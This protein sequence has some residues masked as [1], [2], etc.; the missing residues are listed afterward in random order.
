MSEGTG[1]EEHTN[2]SAAA[3][4]EGGNMA[5]DKAEG[6]AGAAKLAGDEG[7][8]PLA[9]ENAAEAPPPAAEGAPAV[10]EERTAPQAGA[11]TAEVPVPPAKRSREEGGEGA[12]TAPVGGGSSGAAG[13]G[14]GGASEAQAPAEKAAGGAAAGEEKTGAQDGMGG[15]GKKKKA[16]RRRVQW[17]E[18]NLAYWEEHK[19]PR[20]R[21]DEPKTPFH[22]LGPD[23]EEEHLPGSSAAA[24]PSAGESGGAAACVGG[25]S[26]VSEWTSSEDEGDHSEFE[27]WM[28]EQ[29]HTYKDSATLAAAV[30]A[31][32][33]PASLLDANIYYSTG[34]DKGKGKEPMGSVAQSFREHRKRHYDEFKK[35]KLLEAERTDKEEEMGEENGLVQQESEPAAAAAAGDAAA[36]VGG[37]DAAADV[38][39]GAG[40]GDVGGAGDGGAT[41]QGGGEGEDAQG[42]IDNSAVNGTSC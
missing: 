28:E 3:E 30:A 41:I 2:V 19:T 31:G 34:R 1:A 16:R 33:A 26:R 29:G 20:Q 10:G 7:R 17:D 13:G 22:T 38:G 32:T 21:I 11:E 35:M 8:T 14:D 36:A 5:G 18:G 39:V 9:P 12:D 15:Q 23:S 6:A 24:G 4:A 25:S 27:R 42:S 37:G 40:D